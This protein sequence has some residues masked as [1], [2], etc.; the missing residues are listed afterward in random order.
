MLPKIESRALKYGY[1]NARVK[2]MKSLLLKSGFFDDL[3]KTGS[4]EAMIEL[5]HRT[6]Y[7]GD[8]AEASVRY[9]GSELIELAAAKNF[10]RTIARLIRITPKS[11][12]AVVQALL[13]K[14]DLLN[15]KNIMHAKKIGKEYDEVRPYLVPAGGLTEDDFRRLL[16]ADE[17]NIFREVRRTV[18]GEHMLSQS[19][20]DFSKGMRTKFLSALRSLDA[21]M[22]MEAIIDAYSYVLMDKALSES[23]NPDVEAIRRIIKREIDA[24]NVMIIER[25]KRHGRKDIRDHLI[26]GGTLNESMI[27]RLI[28]SKDLA[29]TAGIIRN[30]FRKLE[31]SGEELSDLEIA[32]E[33]S[34]ASQK[35]VVFHR[36]LL[37]VGVIIGFLL[38]KEEEVNNLRKIA[39]GKEFGMSEKDVNEMLVVI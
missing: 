33:K 22:Q 32:L 28:E 2:A 29:Q 10:A 24:K 8:F 35:S 30:K 14:Y 3:V 38:L 25:L 16:K 5:L 17:R 23:G 31:L 12:K 26:R 34:I 20:A 19:T 36:A 39:K 13:L 15:L 27:N 7:K 11:D 37:S 4:V 18:L 1:S 6:T 9:T 21:F